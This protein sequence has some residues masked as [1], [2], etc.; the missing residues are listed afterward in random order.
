MKF[1]LF[2]L[3]KNIRTTIAAAIGDAD[4]VCRIVVFLF[5]SQFQRQADVFVHRSAHQSVHDVLAELQAVV[6]VDGVGQ[7]DNH[8]RLYTSMFQSG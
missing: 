8:L 4:S 2:I 7:T 5:R 1:L 3:L 6:A